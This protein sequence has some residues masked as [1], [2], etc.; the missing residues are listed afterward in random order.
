MNKS[1]GKKTI[2]QIVK[3]LPKIQPILEERNSLRVYK[4]KLEQKVG[5]LEA[6][7]RELEDYIVNPTPAHPPTNPL[8][9]IPKNIKKTGQAYRSFINSQIYEDEYPT[10]KG[11]PKNGEFLQIG[12]GRYDDGKFGPNWTAVDLFDPSP[13][14]DFNYD[15]QDL[16]D[17]WEN[18]FNLIICNAI[19]EHIPYPQK[20]TDEL[21]KVLKPGGYLYVELPFWQK[22]HTGGDSTNGE[23]YGF[24]GDYWRA[25]VEGLRVWMSEFEEVSCGWGNEGVVY[26]FGKKPKSSNKK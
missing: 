15:V 5:K 18:K 26:F 25:T 13:A 19:F 4:H 11:V 21:Y 1:S 14:V 8:N 6:K 10:V 23:E 2:K 3:K 9:Y 7:V 22:Y 16:P 24:G 20:A 12:L 17:D